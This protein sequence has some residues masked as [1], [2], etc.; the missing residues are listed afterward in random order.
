MMMTEITL[1]LFS[2]FFSGKG[3]TVLSFS[4]SKGHAGIITLSSVLQICWTL[5]EPWKVVWAQICPSESHASRVL[6]TQYPHSFFQGLGEWF[7]EYKW[8]N[9]SKIMD[10]L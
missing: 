2:K 3:F 4:S 1:R 5:I 7:L 6:F 10:A 8:I 9:I